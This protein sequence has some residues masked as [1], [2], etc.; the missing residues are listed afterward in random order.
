MKPQYP[1]IFKAFPLPALLLLPDAPHFTIA[2]VNSAYLKISGKNEEDLL[3]KSIFDTFLNDHEWL[4]SDTVFN[5]HQSLLTV[6]NSGKPHTMA[7]QKYNIPVSGSHKFTTRYWD[8]DNTPVP[9]NSEN[10]TGIIHSVVD[11]TEKILQQ[12]K[13]HKFSKDKKTEE[14]NPFKAALLNTIGQAVVT[15]DLDGIINFWNRTAEEMYGWTAAEVIGKNVVD[16]IPAQQTKEQAVEIMKELSQGHSWT[17]EFIAQRKDGRIFPIFA[18]DSPIYDEHHKLAGIIA[19]SNDITKQKEAD[20]QIKNSE[21]RYRTLF[22]QNLAGFYQSTAS[23]VLLKCNDAFVKMLKYN[24][25]KELLE[26]NTTELYFSPGERNDFINNVIDQKRLNNYEGVLKCKDGSALYFLENISLGIDAITGEEFFDGILLDITDKKQAEINLITTS[27]QLQHALT[28]QV[29]SLKKI[30]ESEKRYRRIIDTAQEGIWLINEYD[31]TNFVNKKMCEIIGYS[32][33]ELMGEKIYHFMNDESRKNSLEQIERR[34][35]GISEIHDSTFITKNGKHVWVNISTNPVFDE[36]G[37]YKGA[38][39]M[40]TDITERKQAELQLKESNDRFINVTKATFD[41]IWEYDL[42]TESI[43]WGEGFQ[44]IFGYNRQELKTDISSCTD[45]IHPEDVDRVVKGIYELIDGTGTGWVDE[46]RY[47]K[48][49]Q[50]YAYVIDKG[51]VIRDEQGKVIKMVGAMQDITKKRELENLLDKASKLARIGN[52]E[53]NLIKGTLYWSDITKEIHEAEPGFLPDLPTAINFFKEGTSR[54]LITQKVEDAIE[55]GFSFDVELQIITAKGNEKWVRA[56]GES[57]SASG[58]CVRIYGGFQDIDVRKRAELAVN[59]ALNEKN[60]ILESIGDAFFAVDKN[61]TVTYWNKQAEKVMGKPKNEILDHN[62]W[63]VYSD[64]IDSES[65]KNYHLVVE[66]NRSIHFEDYYPTLNK[67]YA[68][69]A[70]PSGNGLS[71]YFKDVTE[72]KLSEIRLKELN[73]NIQIHAKELAV[74]NAELEQ[75][76]YVA[77]HDL[78]E[79]LRMVTSFLTLLEKKYG[80]IIDDKGKKY[81]GFAV[82]GAK[83]MRQII[84]DLLEFS[85]VGKTED[86]LED[87]DLNELV[88]EIQILFRKQIGEKSAVIGVGELPVLKTYKAP[89]RQV[90]QNLVSNALKYTR[91]YTSSQIQITAR[92]LKTHWQFTVSDNGIGIG[93]EYFD[94]IFILFQRLHNKDEFSGTGMGLALTKKIIENLGG[95]IWV[96]SKEGKGSTF[97]FTLLK[98][99]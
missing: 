50:T 69:S 4:T 71:V 42:I 93:E 54:D 94:K 80:H 46:F 18:T 11:V 34:R 82:D 27:K 57:E 8:F 47:R 75:F 73:E 2:D 22:E 76:A 24:S 79:P 65:Y 14:S 85:R 5:L 99:H 49:D 86:K 12:E 30:E 45:Y 67:W 89:V 70:Y 90:F 62:L 6:M 41:A 88:R 95:K 97:Y 72:S 59:E 68:I 74:S 25:Q 9:D 58:K 61:W 39:A 52:W 84:L 91:E 3:G 38:L 44:T 92:E 21:Q 60:T 53:V 48:A 64:S 16:I 36:E 35:Q 33:E 19:V 78:Q 83:R 15:T 40:I 23:G 81:I 29:I 28:E 56:I 26:I 63:Q 96:E 66:N 17:G 7:T 77:S 13:Q 1:I 87:I 31:Y 55:K 51:F 98:Q 20:V 10:I 43:Y 32:P 37:K